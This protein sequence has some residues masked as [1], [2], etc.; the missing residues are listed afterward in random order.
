VGIKGKDTL[1]VES[2]HYTVEELESAKATLL[3]IEDISAR[4]STTTSR[5]VLPL[6]GQNQLAPRLEELNPLDDKKEPE[7][8]G[9]GFIETSP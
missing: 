1:Q 9:N 4:L 3:E 7:P 2:R 6:R 8:G 5:F